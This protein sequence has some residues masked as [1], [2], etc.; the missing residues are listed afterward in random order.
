M[1]VRYKKAMCGYSGTV[2]EAVYYYHSGM[3]ENL[4]RKYVRPK[5]SM[6]N[7]RL[8]DTMANLKQIAPSA[9]YRRNLKDYLLAYKSRKEHRG[10]HLLTW[11]NLFLRLMFAMEKA[12]PEVFLTT[13]TRE[14]IFAENLPCL[15][16]RQAV[17][18]GLLPQVE[19]Y[20]RLT[21]EI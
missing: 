14:Q 19:G 20:Q 11:N 15:T 10:E 8:R 12:Y 9:G 7:Q 5:I 4:M 1:K 17:E 6:S 2:D 3:D 13:L 18:A 21:Q 16:V